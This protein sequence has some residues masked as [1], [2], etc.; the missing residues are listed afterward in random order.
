MKLRR[1]EHGFTIIELMIATAVFS[2]ILLL[3]T[4]SLI[5]IGR[6]YYK[7][8]TSAKTQ[9]VARLITE[10]VSQA[11]QFGGGVVQNGTPTDGSGQDVYC[12][13]GK[14]YSY[15]KDK[16]LTDGTPTP[17]QSKHVLVVDDEPVCGSVSSQTLSGASLEAGSRELM[18]PNMRLAA[19]SVTNIGNLYTVTV[20][21][22]FGD[23]DLLDGTKKNC[24]SVREG[25]QFCSVSE[26][27]T[28]VQK[29]VQ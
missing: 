22:V 4:F 8:I 26:L 11:I 3:C 1:Q 10:E 9:E 18:G 19:F 23:D 15:I 17:T 16:Q 24:L 5:S 12:I 29:R 27:T 21:V 2:T 13:G 6:S 20:K 14:R 7:G 25:S 28:T